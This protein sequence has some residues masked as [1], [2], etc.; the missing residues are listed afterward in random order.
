VTYD[1]DAENIVEGCLI[2][3]GLE[4]KK[5]YMGIGLN[6]SG[7]KCIEGLVPTDVS[8]SVYAANPEL[9]Q[10]AMSSSSNEARS[11]KQELKKKIFEEFRKLSQPND[12]YFGNFY[13]LVG[14]IN[15]ALCK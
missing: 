11:A 6:E 9:V 7:K 14:V 3:L 12:H 4:K 13:P 8:S 15:R 5:D 10:K 2:G 1:L